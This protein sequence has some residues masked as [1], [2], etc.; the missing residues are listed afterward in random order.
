MAQP[1]SVALSATKPY[2]DRPDTNGMP[3]A[4]ATARL[5]KYA[6]R[7]SGTGGIPFPPVVVNPY[8]P[9]S[10]GLSAPPLWLRSRTAFI[11]RRPEK[12]LSTG[13][14][15]PWTT[16]SGELSSGDR[17]SVYGCTLRTSKK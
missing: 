1:G 3:S 5:R 7:R 13:P 15:V 6:R 12:L 4:A 14:N 9:T 16:V 11:S 8:S 2:Q 17:P 10:T